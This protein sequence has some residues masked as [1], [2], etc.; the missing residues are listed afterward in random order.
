MEFLST[1]LLLY[2]D[3]TK[4]E[5]K[6]YNLAAFEYWVASSLKTWLETHLSDEDTC[7]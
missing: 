4:P 3:F 2:L 5:Y 1:D 7:D 6:A